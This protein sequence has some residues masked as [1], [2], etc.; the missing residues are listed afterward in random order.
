MPKGARRDGFFE[1]IDDHAPPL[2]D[3]KKRSCIQLLQDQ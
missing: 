1:V 3:R 2:S